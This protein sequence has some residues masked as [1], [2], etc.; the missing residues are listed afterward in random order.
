MTGPPGAGKSTL[1]RALAPVIRLPT[2]GRDEIKEGLLHTLGKD[3]VDSDRVVQEAFE[4][5]FD[6][7]ALLL[8]RAVS[9][10]AEAAF[11]HRLW[12]P[13]L[14]RLQTLAQIRIVVC[15]IDPSLALSRRVDRAQ[16]DPERA[17][18][19]PDTMLVNAYDPPRLDLP[20]LTVETA[21]GYD[22]GFDAIVEFARG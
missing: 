2:I 19:H 1:A 11:Q 14:E 22:P 10:I 17:A 9:V 16:A 4:T 21:N 8:D 6:S 18:F 12:A 3:H 7:V 13:R 15:A 20:T 5:F